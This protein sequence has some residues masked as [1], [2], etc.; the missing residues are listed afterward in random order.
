MNGPVVVYRDRSEE[1]EE[2]RDIS[3]VRWVDGEWTAPKTVHSDNWKI[4]GCPVNGPAIATKEEH[5]FVTWFTAEG[6]NPRVLGAFSNDNGET[7]GEAIRLDNGNAIGRLDT[8]FLENG[9]VLVSWLEPKG[10]DVVLQL[11]KVHKDGRKETPITVSQTSSERQSG[12][13]QLEVVGNTAYLAWTHL[14]DDKD[15]EIKIAKV[16]L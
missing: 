5:L 7:F 16:S 1:E 2:T 14:K 8:V 11:A 9:S 10:D 4:N 13:P 3:I 6:D 12:F 15:T